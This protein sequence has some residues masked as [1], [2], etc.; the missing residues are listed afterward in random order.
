MLLNREKANTGQVDI[1]SLIQ[2]LQMIF[3]KGDQDLTVKKKKEKNA[4]EIH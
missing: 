3:Q 2:Y 4:G 1:N